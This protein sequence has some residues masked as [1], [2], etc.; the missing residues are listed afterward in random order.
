VKLKFIETE[1]SPIP[2]PKRVICN[3]E[4]QEKHC[5]IWV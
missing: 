3:L 2:C 1:S 5:K 4:E